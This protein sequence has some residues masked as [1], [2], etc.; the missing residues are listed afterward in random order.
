MIFSDEILNR[1]VDNW[2]Y[3]F[4]SAG[5]TALKQ[6][7]EFAENA[8]IGNTIIIPKNNLIINNIYDFLTWKS[9]QNV[10]CEITVFNERNLLEKANLVNRLISN[11]FID[12]LQITNSSQSLIFKGNGNQFTIDIGK[13]CKGEKLTDNEYKIKQANVD[14]ITYYDNK[15]SFILKD[16]NREISFNC[17]MLNIK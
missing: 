9:K 12:T 15:F 13:I 7:D 2:N 1:I 6:L 5:I 16:L 3:D 10:L 11:K 4:P 8:L 17:K 14:F